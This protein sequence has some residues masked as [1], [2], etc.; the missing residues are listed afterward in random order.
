M[1]D[2]ECSVSS[3]MVRGDE[4]PKHLVLTRQMLHTIILNLKIKLIL[5]I[6]I[7]Y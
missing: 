5:F 7:A 4:K 2:F 6:C 1:S 3:K